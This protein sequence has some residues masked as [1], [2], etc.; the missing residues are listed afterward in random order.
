MISTE[1]RDIRTAHSAP[2]RAGWTAVEGDA[3]PKIKKSDPSLN[4]EQL[5]S[6]KSLALVSAVLEGTRCELK[7]RQIGSSGGVGTVGHGCGGSMCSIKRSGSG[8]TGAGLEYS[9]S[10]GRG[11]RG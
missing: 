5:I 7:N 11:S 8:N 10:G 2:E 4:H 1:G 9:R 3:Y 6:P